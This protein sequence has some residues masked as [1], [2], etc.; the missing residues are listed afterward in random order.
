MTSYSSATNSFTEFDMD[1]QHITLNLSNILSRLILL[2]MFDRFRVICYIKFCK[3][4]SRRRI[5]RHIC[6]IV[7]ITPNSILIHVLSV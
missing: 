3:A 1:V 2:K 6:M 4:V 5:R 7:K